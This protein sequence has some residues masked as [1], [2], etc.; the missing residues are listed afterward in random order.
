MIL[1]RPFLAYLTSTTEDNNSNNWAP[2]AQTVLEMAARK[3]IDSSKKTVDIIYETFR[4]HTFFRCW[5]ISTQYI[6]LPPGLLTNELVCRW[7]NTTYI[8]FAVTNLLLL[9]LRGPTSLVDYLEANTLRD[10]VKKT[11]EI[12]EAMDESVVARKSVEIVKS[13]FKEYC[14]GDEASQNQQPQQQQQQLDS[15]TGAS[16]SQ[17]DMAI[18]PEAFPFGGMSYGEFIPVWGYLS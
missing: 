12:L 2:E 16:I 7:Y 15:E 13:H 9:L 4:Q 10:S 1:F 18:N 6:F 11:I 14:D 17:P 3:C 8:M 5:Y